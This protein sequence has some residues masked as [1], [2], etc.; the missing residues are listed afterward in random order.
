MSKKKSNN[1]NLVLTKLITDVFE[2]SGNKPLNYKQVASKLNLHDDETRVL[3]LEVLKEETRKGILQEPEKGKFILKQLKTFVTG[4]VDMTSDGSAYIVSDDEFEEDIYVAPRKLRNALHGDIVKVYVYAKNKGRKKDGEVVEILQRAKM[5]FTG[6]IK[7]SDRFAFFVPDDRKML[8]D[9]FIPL[10]GLNGAKDGYKAIAKIVDWPEDAKNPIGE[11]THVL[12]KQGENNAEM[13]AILADYG[14]PLAFPDEV[15]KQAESISEDITKEEIARRR[16]FREILTFT[17]DP[18]DAKDFDDAIS[19]QKLKNGNIEVG[20]HIADVSH[21]VKPGS[22]LDKEAFER[23]TSVYLVDRVIP[24]LPERLSNGLCS[25]RPNEDKLCFSAVFELDNDANVVEQ[26]FGRTII[27]SDTR[28]SYED[29]QEVLENKSGKH[30]EELLKL[31]ELAY[32]L[33]ERKFKHGAISFESVEIKFR[34][35]EQGKPLGVY[36]KERKD[37]HKLIEDFMLLANKKVAEF[38]AKKGKGKQKLTFVYRSHDSPKEDALL[39][40]SQFASKFGY[41]IDMSSGRE[42]ARSLNFLMADVEGKKEQNVLTQLAI[43][44]MAKAVY[45]TKKHSHYG[46]AFDY[47]T[48]FTSPIRRY[49]DVMVH[50]LLELY[51]ADGKSV[52]EEE[53]EKMSTHSSQMEKKAADAE[54]ASVKYK[55]A[56]YLQNNIG[57]E[58]SG[59]ISGLTEWGMYVEIIANKCEGMIRLR[60][61]NDDFY[62]LDEKNYCI[63]GQR[64]KK[65]YQ[66]GDEVRILVKKVDLN[67]RQ[68]DFTLVK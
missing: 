50:R 11:I 55:Q 61:L 47:Y 57:E 13:N 63:I 53:Y 32:K 42:T 17:I 43:R 62:V 7:L 4:K 10:D 6:I 30:S 58:F 26:W 56:E 9:I 68:I 37:A 25:L 41:K 33:R 49:P 28:F 16:D 15:E 2:K 14:F 67:K 66:L 36:V 38:V 65:K 1:F 21:Y 46:L 19:F 27:H 52:N 22:A 60:D 51:L 18:A 39:S 64:R 45:T 31:N 44:S 3:I 23:G 12:G 34:L 35:D 20:V 29:A 48:H 8:H 54:R 59:I 24:M 40:F 5:D